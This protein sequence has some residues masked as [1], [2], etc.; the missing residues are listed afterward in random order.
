MSRLENLDTATFTALIGGYVRVGMFDDAL[1][2]F[3]EMRSGFVLDELVIVTV[4]NACVNL[5]KLDYACDLF[6]EMDGCSNV[7]AWNVMISGHGKRGYYKEAVEF[8]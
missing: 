6:D 1:Q 2:L 4:L 7:V 3:D 5:G 8:Y